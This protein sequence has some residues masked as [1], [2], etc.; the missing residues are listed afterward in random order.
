METRAAMVLWGP[1]LSDMPILTKQP[2]LEVLLQALV[3]QQAG[4]MHY[5]C[6]LLGSMRGEQK[7][8]ELPSRRAHEVF[9]E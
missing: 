3:L 4:P 8:W 6:A 2:P 7:Q 5:L 1:L 9:F